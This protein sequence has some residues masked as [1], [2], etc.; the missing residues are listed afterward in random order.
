MRMR[1]LPL[2]LPF[3]ACLSLGAAAEE[4]ALAAPEALVPADAACF[5]RGEGLERL[6]T[7]LDAFCASLPPALALPLRLSTGTALARP[8]IAAA[9]GARPWGLVIMDAA[10]PEGPEGLALLLPVDDPELFRAVSASLVGIQV[11]L[12]RGYAAL[13]AD[14]A[15]LDRIAKGGGGIP[16]PALQ[17]SVVARF[18]P[19]AMA[20]LPLLRRAWAGAMASLPPALAE[21]LSARLPDLA[22][23]LDA[24]ELGVSPGE[25]G[26]RLGLRLRFCPGSQLAA[27]ASAQKSRAPHWTGLA[28]PG[29][30]LSAEV[31]VDAAA[32]AAGARLLL[33]SSPS[34]PARMT[35]AL[36]ASCAG[37]GALAVFRGDRGWQAQ[38][39]LKVTDPKAAARFLAE[40]FQELGA[41]FGTACEMEFPVDAGSLHCQQARLVPPGLAVAGT[42]SRD[43]LVAAAGPES[44][45]RVKV[46]AE[47][48]GD[49]LE[50]RVAPDLAAAMELLPP[51][52]SA[53][54]LCTP[55]SLGALLSRLGGRP[56]HG[57][58]GVVG[59]ACR[60][61][62]GE[63]E[64][65]MVVPGGALEAFPGW[66]GLAIRAGGLLV[67]P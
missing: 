12:V 61:E 28:P 44:L 67:F 66:G 54:A 57:G 51:E 27:L 60:C 15:L 56:L 38:A 29:A 46:T 5:V 52:A 17:E 8:L 9:D 2:L 55:A 47:P 32:G 22:A 62:G 18:R 63:A 3:L 1:R 40:G 53:Y 41:R 43:L 48:L 36:A 21:G 10:R 59:A 39:V 31:H 11:R 65:T 35:E 26:L 33:P 14:A 20:A 7:R 16:A 50:P 42:V 6:K 19:A 45:E 23:Q 4:P 64:F 25:S 58:A 37:D 24:V 13:G 49:G 34:S 30:A